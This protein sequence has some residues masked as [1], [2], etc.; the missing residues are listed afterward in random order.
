MGVDKTEIKKYYKTNERGEMKSCH[1][2]Q[3][4]TEGQIDKK[5]ERKT[6][7]EMKRGE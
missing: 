4:K 6:T 3:K 2:S 7:K 5:S 1:D